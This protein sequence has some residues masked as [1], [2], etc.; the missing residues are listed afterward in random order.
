MFRFR[1]GSAAVAD[2]GDLGFL[3]AGSSY[4]IDY[5]CWGVLL[6]G[7]IIRGNDHRY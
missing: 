3:E 2:C 7:P 5:T 6:S 4:K 1:A